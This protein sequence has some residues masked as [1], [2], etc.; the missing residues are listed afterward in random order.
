MIDPPASMVTLEA[1]V[2]WSMWPGLAE[3]FM[4]VLSRGCYIH[5]ES[6]AED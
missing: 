1:E 2:N 5:A 4:D 6:L 3:A